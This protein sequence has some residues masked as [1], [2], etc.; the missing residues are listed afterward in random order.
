MNNQHLQETARYYA[1]M[2]EQAQIE[3]QEEQ[4]LNQDLIVLVEA[5]CEELGIDMEELLSEDVQTDERNDQLE[6]EIKNTRGFGDKDKRIAD[7]RKLQ[8]KERRSVKIIDKGGREVGVVGKA[9]SKAQAD[10]DSDLAS[11]NAK[12]D[13]QTTGSTRETPAERAAWARGFALRS[14]ED[15]EKE[16][17]QEERLGKKASLGKRFKR[18][19]RKFRGKEIVPTDVDLSGKVFSNDE[20]Y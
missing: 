8:S 20:R 9:T 11:K 15:T 16:K 7:L 5:L 18:A 1:N 13:R 2:A 12:R 14:G 17:A 19:W 10:R 6:K 4:E 3:L